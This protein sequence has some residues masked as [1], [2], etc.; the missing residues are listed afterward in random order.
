MTM[1]VSGNKNYGLASH[2][3]ERW[4]EAEFWSRS[5]NGKD[6]T[7]SV[8]QQEFAERSLDFSVYISCSSLQ[9]FAQTSLLCRVAEQ[10]EKTKKTGHII[11]LGS[12]ADHTTKG[13]LKNYALEKK[14]LREYCRQMSLMAQSLENPAGFKICYLATG[15]LNTPR[16]MIR[17]GDSPH[18]EGRDVVSSIEW[19]LSQPSHLFI[20]ELTLAP[21][22]V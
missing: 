5:S 22:L 20:S 17:F 3:A 12:I 21:V 8:V 10:W 13:N 16:K 11:V 9:G 14:A 19:I 18:I 15:H 2:L 1:L 6:L 7:S 4:P